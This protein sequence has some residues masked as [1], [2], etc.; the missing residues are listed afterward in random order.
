ML[1]NYTYTRF[2]C[3]SQ[4]G[5]CISVTDCLWMGWQIKESKGRNVCP[6]TAYN[7]LRLRKGVFSFLFCCC[8]S[9][10][11]YCYCYFVFKEAQHTWWNF[12]FCYVLLKIIISSVNTKTAVVF[13][14]PF[15]FFFFNSF[16]KQ[17]IIVFS[18]N[19]WLL[20]K[21]VA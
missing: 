15:F 19:L 3:I 14:F 16:Q 17:D 20:K 10:C 2:L 13:C 8:C 9:Y 1:K 6:L 18:I 21:F 4:H 11:F 5:W 12:I 7:F